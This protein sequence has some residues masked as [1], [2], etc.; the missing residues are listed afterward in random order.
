MA[1]PAS[2][3]FTS[4]QRTA[5]ELLFASGGSRVTVRLDLPN[6]NFPVV[7]EAVTHGARHIK[8]DT[9]VGDLRRVATFKYLERTHEILVQADLH[10]ANPPVP[11]ELIELYQA[12][13]QMLAPLV[14][15]G[16]L[17][18]IISVHYIR[19]PLEWTGEQIET[20]RRAQ[21]RAVELL[22]KGAA[23]QSE[24]TA[25][26]LQDAAIQAILDRLRQ[27]LAVNRCTL[28]QDVLDAYAFPVT[29]E[30]R[31]EGANP[32]LGD[33][34][35]IQTSQPVL[36]KLL[37]D[38]SQVVQ[39]DSER[40]STDPLFHT[41]LEHYGGMRAQ[42]V[43]PLFRDDN[44][45]AILSVHQLHTTRNWSTAETDLARN[46]LTLIGRLLGSTP[47]D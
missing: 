40:S 19:G 32:L 34:T 29:H 23:S 38:H 22:E 2:A 20:L 42:I 39:D 43:T 5:E 33:F 45:V 18:G 4:F 6:D 36:E 12:R 30:T 28:R 26:D 9:A 44:L 3:D 7:A 21:S 14:R 13:A 25:S 47:A 11:D 17:A 31:T 8:G 1:M 24:T 41:M 37:A 10:N 46:A 16:K 15:D 35:I 27:S